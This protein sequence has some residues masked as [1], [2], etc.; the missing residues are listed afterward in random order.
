[1]PLL[2]YKRILLPIRAQQRLERRKYAGGIVSVP[3]GATYVDVPFDTTGWET[4]I[5]PDVLPQVVLLGWNTSY[6]VIPIPPATDFRTGFRVVFG[7]AAPVSAQLIW[8]ARVTP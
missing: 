7:A 2:N 8:T 3:G 1:M 6:Q 4:S 5:T